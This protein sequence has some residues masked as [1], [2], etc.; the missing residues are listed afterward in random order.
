MSP[1]IWQI[2]LVLVL[3][4]ILFGAGKLPRVMGDIAKGVKNFKSG[5]REPDEDEA[6]ATASAP[7]K[8]VS[9]A[10]TEAAPAAK[11]DVT[12]DEPAKT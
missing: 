1:S 10:A 7:A 9:H 3:V 12:T 2:L 6:E 11:A 4:L 8:E 5:L